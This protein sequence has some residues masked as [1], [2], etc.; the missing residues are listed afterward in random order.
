MSPDPRALDT[1]TQIAELLAGSSND[2]QAAI[3]AVFKA[4]KEKLYQARPIGLTKEITHAI[5][6][7]VK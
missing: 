5:K 4:E 7:I 3:T 6:D 2:T 1:R